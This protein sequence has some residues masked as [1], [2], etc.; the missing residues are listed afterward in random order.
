MATIGLVTI[1]QAPR[2]DIEATM[3][4]GGPPVPC[5]HAGA[6]D[7]LDPNAIAALAPRDGEIPLVTRLRDGQEVVVAK[8]SVLPLL[9]GAVKRVVADG[10]RVVVVLCTGEFPG[11]TAPVPLVF[12]DR[13]LRGTVDAL[14]PDSILGVLMPHPGQ[15]PLMERKWAAPGRSLRCAAASPYT[16]AAELGARAEEL[17]SAGAQLIVMDCMGYTA[18][19]KQAVAT[20]GVPTILANRLVGR[21]VEEIVTA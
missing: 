11:L 18:E 7:G 4:P 12:P 2:E 5:Q 3:F 9:A 21:V 6:L 10:A 14:L 19:M 15:G 8:E 17:R 13:V 16:G 1:G 20:A